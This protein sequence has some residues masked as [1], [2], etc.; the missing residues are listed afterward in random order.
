MYYLKW[1]IKWL[2]E[3]SIK[4]WKI[5]KI[6][7]VTKLFRKYYYALYVHMYL[8]TCHILERNLDWEKPRRKRKVGYIVPDVCTSLLA[9]SWPLQL[10]FVWHSR[11]VKCTDRFIHTLHSKSTWLKSKETNNILLGFYA[12]FHVHAK[13][14]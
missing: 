2:K 6:E 14:M 7:N 12:K 10:T 3:H 1:L 8:I 4:N 9:G 5:S 11:V 13:I